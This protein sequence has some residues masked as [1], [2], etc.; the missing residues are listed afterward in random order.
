MTKNIRTGMAVFFVLTL[1][2]SANVW[3]EPKSP[4]P[5]SVAS[6]EENAQAND[7]VSAEE[8]ALD[9]TNRRYGTITN[10][11][12]SVWVAAGHKFGHNAYQIGGK[13]TDFSQGTSGELHFPISELKW[14]INAIMGE[15]GGEVHLGRRFALRGSVMRNLTNNLSGK[16]EDSDWDYDPELYGNKPDV[17]SESA[18]DFQG[19]GADLSAR[20]WI[21]ERQFRNRSSF[22][23]G[24]GAGF[25]YQDYFW[26]ASNLDQWYPRDPQLGHDYAG[27]PVCTYR[28]W[29]Y[30]PYAE[31]LLKSKLGRFDVSASLGGSPYLWAKD[32]DNHLLRNRIMTTDATGYAVKFGL[33]GNYAF[34]QNIFAGLRVNLLYYSAKGTQDSHIYADIYEGE[35]WYYAGHRW[36]IEHEIESVQI[37]GLLTLGVRF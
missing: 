2:L 22:A 35:Q 32:E 6:D 30:M 27:G 8:P 12:F 5:A 7:I 21:F 9:L 19:H 25:L 33:E 17:Y 29:L 18:T 11:R 15:V 4:S 1:I 36:E 28:S 37:D 31:F 24:V 23:M 10:E 16:M 3:A 14:P 13:F 26:V 34:T 20:Y